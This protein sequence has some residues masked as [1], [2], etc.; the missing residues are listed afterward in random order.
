MVMVAG[1]G[2][3]DADYK[4]TDYGPDSKQIWSCPFYTYWKSMLYRTYVKPVSKSMVKICPEWH[5]F[6]VFREWMICQ[7]WKNKHLDKDLLSGEHKIYSPETCCFISKSLNAILTVEKYYHSKQNLPLGVTTKKSGKFCSQASFMGVKKTLGYFND[8]L[9]AH[10]AWQVYKIECLHLYCDKFKE[11]II[12][13]FRIYMAIQ[14]I[15]SNIHKDLN[16]AKETKK[17]RGDI[18]YV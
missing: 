7:N 1:R 14:N 8:P 6:S 18:A 17:L 9:L 11:E 15:I 3:N 2:I 5:T 10:Q 16:D 12:H 13:D 4:V